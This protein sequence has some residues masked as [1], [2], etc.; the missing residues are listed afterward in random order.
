MADTKYDPDHIVAPTRELKLFL[1]YCYDLDEA[2]FTSDYT[3]VYI[4][5]E[6]EADAL[7]IFRN[8]GFTSPAMRHYR[9]LAACE[10]GI[11]YIDN[12]I[13]Y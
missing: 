11:A 13:D 1:F 3:L 7:E 6:N 12:T 4:F 8:D 9:C 10:R 2:G 5:A